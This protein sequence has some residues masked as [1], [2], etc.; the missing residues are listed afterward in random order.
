MNTTLLVNL[1]GQTYQR[2]DLF[3]E[4]PITLVI[5]QS[6]LTD[7][8]ARR[9][10]YSKTIQLPDTSQNALVFEHYY[11]VNGV[12]FNPLN[13]VPCVVQYRGTDIFRGVLR[14]NAVNQTLNERTYEVYILGDV[15]DFFSEIRDFDLQEL[16]W[17]EYTHELNYTAVTESWEAKADTTDGLF[18]GDILYPLVNYGLVYTGSSTTPFWSYD[19]DTATSF[20]L[21]GNP[22]S[23]AAFKP[24]IRVKKVI[25]KI[26]SAS[27]YTYQSD[28]FDTDYFKSIY[29]DTFQNGKIGVDSASAVTNQNIFK[30]FT[31]RILTFDSTVTVRPLNFNSTGAGGY[32]PLGNFTLGPTGT[33]TAVES[34]FRVPYG[35]DYFFNFRCQL[36]NVGLFGSLYRGLFIANAGSDLTTLSNGANTFFSTPTFNLIAGSGSVDVN[37][38]FS[39][40]VQQGDYVKIYLVTDTFASAPLAQIQIGAYST[41]GI[42]DTAPQWDL[43]FSPEFA[44]DRAVVDLN[45]G[46]PNL[47]AQDFMK[48]MITMFNLVAVQDVEE[49]TVRFEPYNWYYN[50]TDRTQQDWTNRVDLSQNYRIE[51]LSFD[52]SKE[53]IWTNLDTEN[54]YLNKQF[55]DRFDFVYGRKKFVTQNNLFS[56]IQRYELPFGS[57]PTSGVTNAPNFIIPQFYYEINGNQTPYATKPHL[58]FWVGNRYAYKD[59]YKTVPG[60]W[61]M[62]S[63]TTVFEQTTYPAV[64]HLS[65]LD[66]QLPALVSDLNFEGTFDFFGN[67]NTQPVQFTQNTVYNLFWNDYIENIYSPETRRVTCKV[68]LTPVLLYQTSLQDK[69]WLKD[70]NYT[71]EKINEADLVNKKTTEVQLIK[72]RL[73]YYKI[74]PPAPVYALSGNTPYPGVEPV[75]VTLCWVDFDQDAVCNET[76]P[77]ISI[78]TFGSGTIGNWDKVYYDTGTQLKLLEAGYYLKQQGIPSPDTFV[79]IDNYGRIL[80]QPC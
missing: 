1:S 8:S 43:Y 73:P 72:D 21:S 48:S 26:F 14:L 18:D 52:L 35:G 36:D 38:F 12:D 20:S 70:A 11:E 33:Q 79:V 30:V 66:I 69:I 58:F 29:M 64:S 62:S 6:D 15:A 59:I 76:A 24:A 32:D 47:N 22:V 28:F 65:S 45:L 19:F 80:E 49:K 23:P 50:D 39:G 3:E 13:K 44:T 5:Q 46:I 53:V 60:Y 9:V 25:D 37:Y 57:V 27:T 16:N 78:Y 68:F 34:Y 67:S 7:L 55:T 31:N 41:V 17:V 4:L 56:G 51:P 10:P 75:Y 42:Q 40:T 63:G 61:Y 71:I 77:L 2:L 54:E 74:V